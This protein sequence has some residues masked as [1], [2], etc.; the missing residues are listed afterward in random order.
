MMF[1][2]RCESVERKYF[3]MTTRHRISEFCKVLHGTREIAS[4][5]FKA[6]SGIGVMRFCAP[7]AAQRCFCMCG[8]FNTNKCRN[9]HLYI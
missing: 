2:L 4:G 1:R 7:D 8:H 3:N 6:D 9:I 5:D